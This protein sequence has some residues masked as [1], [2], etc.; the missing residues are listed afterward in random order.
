MRNFKKSL[1]GYFGEKGQSMVF[2]ETA[3]DLESLPHIQIDCIP[4][5]SNLEEDV[6]LF[7]KKALTEDD[8]E[9]S[10]HKK[11][12]DTTESK[13]DIQAVIPANFS[14]FHIDINA[15]GGFAHVIEDS[16]RFNRIHALEVLAGCMGEEN[17]N[18]NVPLRYED[19]RKR[20]KKFKE[21]YDEKYNWTRY[22]K[23]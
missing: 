22:K 1:V 17:V 11:I 13:G 3:A 5:D 21:K 15:Q 16:K 6:K 4:I 7:F 12:Y 20:V 18:L 10:T 9:W 23:H 19:L 8:E 14:Y 2:L